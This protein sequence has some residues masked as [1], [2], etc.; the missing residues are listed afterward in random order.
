MVDDLEERAAERGREMAGEVARVLD[1]DLIGLPEGFLQ[2][3]DGLVCRYARIP[4]GAAGLLG[5]IHVGVI[6]VVHDPPLCCRQGERRRARE[7]VESSV[8]PM[9]A[10]SRKP[11]GLRWFSASLARLTV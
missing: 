7:R 4:D 11:K 5:R 2:L 1:R 3:S 6:V 8:W 10:V 9:E